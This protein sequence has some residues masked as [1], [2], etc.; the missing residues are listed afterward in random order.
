MGC[1]DA[2][3]HKGEADAECLTNTVRSVAAGTRS[4]HGYVSVT[5]ATDSSSAVMAA[6]IKCIVSS[7]AGSE[8]E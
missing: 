3:Y 6:G 1:Y 7:R 5:R 8:T 2:W 4:A